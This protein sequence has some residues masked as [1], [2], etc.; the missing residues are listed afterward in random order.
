[1]HPNA[2]WIWL[3]H[4]L[5]PGNTKINRIL[6]L[7][8]TISNFYEA[9]EYEWRL[10]GCFTQRELAAFS[11]YSLEEAQALMEYCQ[12]VG[13]QVLTPE[14]EA[15]P[16]LLRHIHPMP[17]ALYVWGTLPDW[18][19][20][21]AIAVVGTRDATESGKRIA[22]EFSYQLAK[23]GC[24]VVSGGALGIDTA[25]HKGALQAGGKTLCVLG[26]GIGYGYL[27]ENASLREAIAGSGALISEFP[28]NTPPSKA[29]FPIRN[30][31]IS[32]LC[33]G[34]LVVEAASK[35][36]S[37]ITA[38]T[39]LEQNRDVFAVPCDIHN[40]VSQGANRLI[41][42]GAKAVTC[43]ED[44]LE[45]Y[46]GQFPAWNGTESTPQ[47]SFQSHSGG[48]SPSR[49][50]E[51]APEIS[52]NEQTCSDSLSAEARIIWKCLER[53][54]KPIAQLEAETGLSPGRLLAA[55]TE[56]E[57]AGQAVSYSGRR[58]GISEN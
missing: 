11:S 23:Y 45:E 48:L 42:T 4:G 29:T 46:Q 31:L 47:G 19:A 27:M 54:P 38:Q 22:F 39:A 58:Y 32:G 28:V 34:T 51:T 14:D 3:Q 30:R 50:G 53:L 10:S 24:V 36:G 40:P 16:P 56:L 6:S 49:C 43:V 1:M 9:G 20:A 18:E 52:I 13:Q 55:L 33:Q 5:G 57:L 15:F 41:Q 7:F 37:L 44:I 12:T 26:C 21:P 17:C 35:S 8:H 25:A 2:Y